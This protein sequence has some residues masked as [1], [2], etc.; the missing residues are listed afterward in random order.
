[1]RVRKFSK[2]TQ[3]DFLAGKKAGFVFHMIGL[4][5]FCMELIL[6]HWF[7]IIFQKKIHVREARKSQKS[8]QGIQ[9]ENLAWL[10][11]KPQPTQLIDDEIIPTIERFPSMP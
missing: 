7:F 2:H 3:I 8:F 6:I 5:L 9:I 11:K 10:E 1:M 4:D